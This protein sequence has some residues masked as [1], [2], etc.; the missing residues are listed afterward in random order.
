MDQQRCVVGEGFSKAPS[1]RKEPVSPGS[2]ENNGGERH[3]G[4]LEH[5]MA[6][7]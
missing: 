6:E 2:R 3:S 7:E 1:D 4:G 5:Q